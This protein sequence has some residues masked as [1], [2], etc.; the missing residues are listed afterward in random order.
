MYVRSHIPYIKQFMISMDP[1]LDRSKFEPSDLTDFFRLSS[2][3]LKGLLTEPMWF[4]DYITLSDEISV[5]SEQSRTS[6]AL[7]SRG[8]GVAE[9]RRLPYHAVWQHPELR[10]PRDRRWALDSRLPYSTAYWYEQYWSP[11]LSL[12]A[13]YHYS[14][15]LEY[16]II[17][18]IA[19]GL[20]CVRTSAAPTAVP[21]YYDCSL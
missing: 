7:P 20:L 15:T 18:L 13:P 9:N 12:S 17:L 14:T 10:T 1:K 19:P 21:Y 2:I 6:S 3:S 8:P 4:K 5:L 16:R 11:W